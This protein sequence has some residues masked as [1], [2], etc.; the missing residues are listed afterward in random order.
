MKYLFYL[1]NEYSIPVIKPLV[2]FL[3]C[4]SP[5]D[6][7]RFLVSEKVA[8][9]FPTEWD[10]SLCLDSVTATKTFNP[11]FVLSSE[12]Y[13][14][15]RIPGAKVQLFHGVGV[16]KKSHFVIRHFYDIYLTSGPYVTKRFQELSKR[17]GYFKVFETGW[18]KFDHILSF[19]LNKSEH[20]KSKLKSILYAPTFSRKMQSATALVDTILEE[21]KDDEIW[22]IKF[23][24]LMN[25]E[26]I[27]Q[28]ENQNQIYLIKESDITPYLYLADVMISDTS[29]VIY[30][31]LGLDKP[32]ITYQT[33]DNPQK[34]LNIQ[35]PRE[36]RAALDLLLNNPTYNREQRN[37]MLREVNPY[38]DGKIA[39]RVFDALKSVHNDG[40]DVVK[41]KPLNWFRKAKIILKKDN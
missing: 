4:H 11:D 31:F 14:D 2:R 22:Y 23:H 19:T 29:S 28:F 41:S 7:Y 38:L 35:E 33:L 32:V 39:S 25:P 12:N 17:Y 3:A 16:E 8:K 10:V 6:I 40:M 30:E 5:S 34:G 9:K 20:P 13:I 27:K 18:P 36:L 21:K 15:Y 1:K 37:Q 24:E 26:I